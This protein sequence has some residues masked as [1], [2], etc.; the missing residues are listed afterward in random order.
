MPVP[1]DTGRVD[2]K[3][4]SSCSPRHKEKREAGTTPFLSVISV[5]GV[6][7]SSSCVR[8]HSRS[9]YGLPATTEGANMDASAAD[10]AAMQRDGDNSKNVGLPR[11]SARVGRVC[12]VL[13]SYVALSILTVFW[14]KHLVGGKIPT[15]LVL[16]WVQQGVGLLLH[17]VISGAVALFCG[18][19]SAV[20]RALS[21][22]VPVIRIRPKLM[23]R[24]LP[25][26]FCFVGMI[27]FANM[28][29]QRVQVSVYQVARSLTLV[30]SLVLSVCWLKQRVLKG[31]I[32]SC[33]LVSLGFALMTVVGAETASVSGYL[34]GA[35]ASLFQATYMVKMKA[36]LNDLQMEAESLVRGT[37]PD[38]AYRLIGGASTPANGSSSAAA[39]S[40]KNAAEIPAEC[41]V[42]LRGASP[43]ASA[44]ER[45]W[46]GGGVHSEAGLLKAQDEGSSGL[47]WPQSFKGNPPITP[48]EQEYSNGSGSAVK[49]QNI[50]D[51]GERFA[52]GNASGH[53]ENYAPRVEPI[54]MFYNMLNAFC[55]FPIMIFFSDEPRILRELAV[56]GSMLSSALLAQIF[57]LGVVTF[58]L[59]TSVFWA[60]SLT[61]PLSF[62]VAGYVKTLLQ[63]GVAT[64]MWGERLSLT[65]V[66]GFLLTLGG[67]LWYSFSR[68]KANA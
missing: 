34:M 39:E 12:L 37:P 43:D 28:C 36:T 26:S 68:W 40:T 47:K 16:S 30:F 62:A 58:V 60:V 32:L 22:A 29:L 54:C 63:V 48:L 41:T 17:V 65:E 25:L 44:S 7:S 66:C 55:I 21:M 4:S 14:T 13:G 46:Q 50:H 11:L 61:S 27:G 9:V 5:P 20:G 3:I 42:V 57:F 23:M 64:A 18:H 59:G 33:L 35:L 31:D 51:K 49:M 1:Y 56:E 45:S 19:Q 67:S 53:T 8:E 38:S 2:R 15:P 10:Q 52:E 6:I 24:M